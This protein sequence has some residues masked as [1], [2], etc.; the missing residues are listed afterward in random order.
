M[1]F[2]FLSFSQDYANVDQLLALANVN[3]EALLSYAYDAAVFSAGRKLPDLEFARNHK[4]EADV[5]MFDFTCMHRAENASMVMERRGKKLLIGL[6]GDCLVEVCVSLIHTQ[7]H[8]HTLSLASQ[9]S[10]MFL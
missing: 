1:I 6:V 10:L 8:T 7:S 5:A 3:G 2:Y 9:Y 4:G